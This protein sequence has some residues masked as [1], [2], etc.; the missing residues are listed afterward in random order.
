MHKLVASIHGRQ[1]KFNSRIMTGRVAT[2][3]TVEI[4]TSSDASILLPPYWVAKSPSE[5]AVGKACIKVQTLITSAG[6]L[7]KVNKRKV[8]IGPTI[9]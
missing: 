5:V 9:S 6:N 4:V 1:E 2:D 8:A 7:S 3:K